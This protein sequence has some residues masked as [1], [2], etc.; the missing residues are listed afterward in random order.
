M[1]KIRWYLPH[2]ALLQVLLRQVCVDAVLQELHDS[3]FN[4]PRR[5]P[6]PTWAPQIPLEGVQGVNFLHWT[7]RGRLKRVDSALRLP[8]KSSFTLVNSGFLTCAS[9]EFPPFGSPS[10]TAG[11]GTYSFFNS[12]I[13]S[14]F[15][16]RTACQLMEATA[17]METARR[18]RA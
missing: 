6:V 8:R 18:A 11:P 4:K 17:T 9:L 1:R 12:F 2:L 5:R 16:R 7:K 3:T 10:C 13:G 15:I 14:E